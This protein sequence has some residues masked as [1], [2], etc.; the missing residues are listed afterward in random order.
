MN[1]LKTQVEAVGLIIET[2][3]DIRAGSYNNTR[4]AIITQGELPLRQ[5]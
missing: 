4:R 5:P 3:I 1:P 2:L